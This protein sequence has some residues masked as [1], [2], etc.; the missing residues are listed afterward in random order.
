M[1]R[2]VL[3]TGKIGSG[4]SA[5]SDLLR[6]KHYLVVDSDSAVKKL[7]DEDPE[8]FQSVVEQ[9]G[10]ACL[11]EDGT[12]NKSYLSQAVLSEDP[13]MQEKMQIVTNNVVM[14]LLQNLERF[15]EDWN[16]VVF[17]E[18]A[19]T[20]EL[21][22]CRSYLSMHDVLMVKMDETVRQERLKMRANYEKTKV[23]E[24]FQSEDNLNL[25]R[26]YGIEQQLE[27]PENLIVLDNNGSLDDLNNQ[28]MEVLEFRLKLTHKEKL[29]TYIRYLQE[30]PDYC[31]DNAWCYSFYNCGGCATCPFPCAKQ[32]KYYKKLNEDFNKNH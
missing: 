22:W 1:A 32:D 23:F 7:Y 4:K 10:P 2:F 9:F 28:L 30:C 19:L 25:Y 24:K 11:K 20:T 21:G 12:I 26:C 14:R 6:K 18:A 27:P 3:I 8:M 29:A 31:H 13:E 16:E 5:V 15:Y 17:V